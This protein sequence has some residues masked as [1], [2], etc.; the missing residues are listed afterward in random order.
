MAFVG[1]SEGATT[2]FTA[3]TTNEADWFKERISIFAALATVSRLDNLQSTLLKVLGANDLA[4]NIVKF[5]GIREWFYPNIYTRTLFVNICNYLPQICEF[6]LKTISDGDPSV[7]DRDVLR[8]YLGHFPG[9]LSVKTLDHELQ[10]YKAKRFQQYDYGTQQNMEKYGSDTP[11]LI[12]VEKI[13]GIPIAMMAGTS[14]LLGDVKD[15]EWLRD[16]LGSDVIFYKTYDYGCSSFYIGKDMRYLE[17]LTNVLKQYTNPI[18]TEAVKV[19]I[20]K[21]SY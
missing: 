5:F 17:D 9:G 8:I 1:H 20:K 21:E 15:N 2:L 19:Q 3:L 18:T 12:P 14:D 4:L 7:N 13:Y 16:Q 6:N 10:I 11:P